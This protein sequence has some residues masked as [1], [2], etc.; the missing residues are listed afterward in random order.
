M[1]DYKKRHE[2]LH[3]QIVAVILYNMNEKKISIM[4]LAYKLC[5]KHTEIINWLTNPKNLRISTIVDIE[6][7]L[8]CKILSVNKNI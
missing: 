1:D 6:F 3:R 8:D 4:D 5:K 7:A 2:E